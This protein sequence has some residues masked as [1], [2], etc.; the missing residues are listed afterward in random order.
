[1]KVTLKQGQG[2]QLMQ[3][4]K[5]LAWTVS[6]KRPTIVSVKSGNKSMIS[7]EYVRKSKMV[8]IHDLL[9]ILDNTTKFQLN[10]RRT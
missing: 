9:D 10:Q 4:L 6:M 7:P 8:S 1:M 3:I 5:N 2:H